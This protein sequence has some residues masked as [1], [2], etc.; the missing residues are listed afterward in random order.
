MAIKFDTNLNVTYPS[1]YRQIDDSASDNIAQ[2]V[3]NCNILLNEHQNNG[4]V[5]IS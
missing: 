2:T 1:H 3:I 5:E 4:P